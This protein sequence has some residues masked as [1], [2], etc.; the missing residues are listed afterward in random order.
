MR[1]VPNHCVAVAT[2]STGV[3]TS[4]TGTRSTR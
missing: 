2:S 4:A 3:L 1:A